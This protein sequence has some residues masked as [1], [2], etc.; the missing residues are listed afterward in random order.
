MANQQSLTLNLLLQ[1]LIDL[2]A[3][4]CTKAAVTAAKTFEQFLLEE[5]TC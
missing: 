1:E 5:Y 2:S 3:V 4:A